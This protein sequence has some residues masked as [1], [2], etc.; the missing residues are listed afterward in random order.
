L[1][2]RLVAVKNRNCADFPLRNSKGDYE[3]GVILDLD[4]WLVLPR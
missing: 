1:R 2:T 3:E 4:C